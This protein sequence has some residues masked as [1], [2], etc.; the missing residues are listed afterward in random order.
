M[1]ELPV[2]LEDL[3]VDCETHGILLELNKSGA[4]EIEAPKDVLTTDL[5]ARLKAHKADLLAL[6]R[7]FAEPAPVPPAQTNEG[8]GKREVA[9]CRC[10]SSTWQ[11]FPIHDGPSV[12]R[13]CGRCGRFLD[14]PVWYGQGIS[15]GDS[16]IDNTINNH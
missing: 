13:A 11:D 10:G 8:P 5:L 9:V 2:E 3:L 6:L 15:T 7:Q 14:F 12:R 16:F 4:L 1:I